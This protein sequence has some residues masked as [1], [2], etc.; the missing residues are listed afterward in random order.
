MEVLHK[1]LLI[2]YLTSRNAAGRPSSLK[3]WPHVTSIWVPPTAIIP[4]T[5]IRSQHVS[6][7]VLNLLALL[8]HVWLL[9]AGG[10]ARQAHKIFC[11][12][13]SRFLWLSSTFGVWKHWQPFFP[14]ELQA[15]AA[16]KWGLMSTVKASHPI[17]CS[18]LLWLMPVPKLS[19]CPL[20]Y[21]PPVQHS[22]PLPFV[23]TP[24]GVKS[25][26]GR[27]QC[28]QRSEKQGSFQ[29]EVEEE[30]TPQS[31]CKQMGSVLVTGGYNPSFRSFTIFQ[32][33]E[34]CGFPFCHPQMEDKIPQMEEVSS[35]VSTF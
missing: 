20:P 30:G 24:D 1:V 12:L 29:S 22:K 7:K 17:E 33:S 5:V 14:P 21:Q 2:Y 32:C 35:V 13:A 3:V 16:M 31:L 18:P 19:V 23:S 25:R 10:Q 26:Q 4:I 28:S 34:A 8:V 9:L 6:G 27:Q 11:P 15:Q